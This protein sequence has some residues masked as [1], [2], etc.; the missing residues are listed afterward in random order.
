MS[1]AHRTTGW[2]PPPI[3]PRIY[4]PRE[5]LALRRNRTTRI[6][7]QYPHLDV[8]WYERTWRRRQERKA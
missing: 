8:A 3:T 4:S 2:Q 1:D 5:A 6:M 7:R